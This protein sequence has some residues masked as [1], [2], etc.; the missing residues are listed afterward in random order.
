[1]EDLCFGVVKKLL[2]EGPYKAERKLSEGTSGEVFEV[3][4]SK[5]QQRFALKLIDLSLLSKHNKKHEL[6]SE[7]ALLKRLNH[8]GIVKPVDVLRWSEHVGLVMELGVYG[9][10]FS[11][12]NLA[13][14]SIEL[15]SRLIEFMRFYLAQALSTIDYLHSQGVVH[16]DIKVN[17]SSFSRRTS[18]SGPTGGFDSLTLEL[19]SSPLSLPFSRLRKSSS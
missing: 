10:L 14:S 18:S 12:I 8:P 5:S 7:I 6:V 17:A 3:T 9:D 11:F 4:H 13:H 19:P 16:R 1:M 15:Q 2:E